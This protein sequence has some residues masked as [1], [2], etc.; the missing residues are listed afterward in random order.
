MSSKD[1]HARKRRQM[2]DSLEPAR[3]SALE[4]ARSSAVVESLVS[5]AAAD[6][7]KQ[8]LGRADHISQAFFVAAKLIQPSIA[9]TNSTLPC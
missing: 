3:R 1:E 7:A 6:L 9:R 2:A 8:R 4:R 5:V